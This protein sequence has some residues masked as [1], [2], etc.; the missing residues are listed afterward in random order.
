MRAF[1]S[2]N[3]APETVRRE[4]GLSLETAVGLGAAGDCA[5]GPAPFPQLV[6]CEEFRLCV[7]TTAGGP[8]VGPVAD[9]SCFT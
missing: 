6:R 4:W 3:W 2:G 8:V 5:P 7:P 1:W 9:E